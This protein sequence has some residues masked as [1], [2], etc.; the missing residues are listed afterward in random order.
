MVLVRESDISTQEAGSPPQRPACAGFPGRVS[1]SRIFTRNKE[2]RKKGIVFISTF[3]ISRVYTAAA[4]E[5]PWSID[6]Y[7]SSLA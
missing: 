1:P 4:L 2:N 7:Y 5:R 3:D 6:F